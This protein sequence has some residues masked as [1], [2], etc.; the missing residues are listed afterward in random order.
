MMPKLMSYA[1]LNGYR[2]NVNVNIHRMV[3]HYIE[4]KVKI[5]NET[6]ILVALHVYG[7]LG[8]DTRAII[9]HLPT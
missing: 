4:D 7:A 8:N 5:L 9:M 1:H 3:V 6:S 2:Y